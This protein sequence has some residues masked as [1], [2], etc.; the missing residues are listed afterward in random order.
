MG[1][2]ADGP[3]QRGVILVALGRR[4]GRLRAGRGVRPAS[5]WSWSAG[6]CRVFGLGLL[7]VT[8]A[9]ARQPPPSEKAGRAIAT[10]SIT[11]AV[12]AGLGYPLTGLIAQ[13]FDFHAAFWFGAIT[14]GLALVLVVVVLPGRSDAPLPTVRHRRR[15][16][17]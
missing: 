13:V 7:P 8:M 9:I 1:R 4:P 10:L 12:G 3:R 5:S 11:A 6:P 2:L 16:Q 15:R 14:V 17:L